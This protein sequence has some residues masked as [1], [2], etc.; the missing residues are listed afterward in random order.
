MIIRAQTI[1]SIE[2]SIF[3]FVGSNL[4]KFRVILS[5]GSK[6]MIIKALSINAAQVSDSF[7]L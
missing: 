5:A 1:N 7:F 2:N 6:L 3:F 4:M